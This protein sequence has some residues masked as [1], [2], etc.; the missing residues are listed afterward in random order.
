MFYCVELQYFISSY[1]T[2][3]TFVFQLIFLLKHDMVIF[4]RTLRKCFVR[5]GHDSLFSFGLDMTHPPSQRLAVR[6]SRLE[7]VQETNSFFVMFF[8][9]IISLFS[10]L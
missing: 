3:K 10:I 5:S 7:K 9:P 2:L 6:S 1:S 4:K 8:A